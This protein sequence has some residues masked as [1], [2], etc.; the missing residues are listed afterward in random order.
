MK[1]HKVW[2]P[3]LFAVYSILFL[4]A[5]NVSEASFGDLPVPT[6]LVFSGIVLI[7]GLLW[8]LFRNW[9]FTGI[10]VTT[11][12]LAF[13][14]YGHAYN[15]VLHE[16]IGSF[17]I[18]RHRHLFPV[19]ALLFLIVSYLAFRSRESLGTLTKILNFTTGV[20][21]V[22]VIAEISYFHIFSRPDTKYLT[23]SYET[24]PRDASSKNPDVYYIIL[25]GY[26]SNK[27]IVDYYETNNDDFEGYLKDKG[28]YISPGS[29]SNYVHTPVSLSSS[30]NMEYVNFLA[31]KLGENSVDKT[32]PYE[33]IKNSKA[34]QFL[35]ARGY[36]F[37]LIRSGWG[38]TDKNTAADVSIKCGS[39]NEY[40]KMMTHTTMLRIFEKWL[41]F[42]DRHRDNVRK[43]FSELKDINRIDG[44]KFV[45]VHFLVPHAPFIF[46]PNGEPRLPEN[47]LLGSRI[48][49]PRQGYID[50]IAYINSQMKLA[51]DNILATS[52]QTPI[53]MIQADHGPAS[54]DKWDDPTDEFLKE[55]FGIINA[56]LLSGVP[57]D[58]LRSVL[59]PVNNFRLVFNQAFNTNFEILEDKCWYSNLPTPYKFT[60]VTDRVLGN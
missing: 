29:V 47:L 23:N 3:I 22:F 13:F 6:L 54:F 52:A 38:P 60:D 34:M 32:I 37:V 49:L 55:R 21:L 56:I 11:I 30:M 8:V 58:S 35:K 25:D 17:D 1:K 20:L 19:Y 10:I 53:I 36:S 43:M 50:Q 41:I 4:F 12:I 59:T 42:L 2:H 28:F 46:G 27:T 48:W 40:L 16:H 57:E 44:P 9:Q 26:A 33:M 39:Y 14:T 51:I 31:D 5:H 18:G 15:I 45:M 24:S 7:W